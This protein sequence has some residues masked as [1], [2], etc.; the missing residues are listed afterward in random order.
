MAKRPN[1][2]SVEANLRMNPGGQGLPPM[3]FGD[4]DFLEQ[5]LMQ[6]LEA[7]NLQREDDEDEEQTF[8]PEEPGYFQQNIRPNMMA[9][10]DPAKG[11]GDLQRSANYFGPGGSDAENRILSSLPDSSLLPKPVTDQFREEMGYNDQEKDLL[12][13]GRAQAAMNEAPMNIDAQ[14]RSLV[15]QKQDELRMNQFDALM[16]D[17]NLPGYEVT[18]NI[19]GSYGPG[20]RKV[21]VENTD[22]PDMTIAEF[23]E[24]KKAGSLGKS[25]VRSMTQPTKPEPQQQPKL[26]STHKDNVTKKPKTTPTPAPADKRGDFAPLEGET[27]ADFQERTSALDPN[28][29]AYLDPEFAKKSQRID[30]AFIRNMEARGYEKGRDYDAL[31][32]DGV[33][34]FSREISEA[35]RYL[36]SQ[37]DY[38]ATIDDLSSKEGQRASRMVM[39]SEK[40]LR[41]AER[42]RKAFGNM[43]PAVRGAMR[44]RDKLLEKS[45]ELGPLE[46][47]D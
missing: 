37:R 17:Y 5:Y 3:S 14:R 2:T 28:A 43:S 27:F 21:Q 46:E 33:E 11:F 7:Q 12:R 45:Y 39:A 32:S 24:R 8:F 34:D 19:A 30:D 47:E 16:E 25:G 1:E 42:K 15:E 6:M 31:P 22:E 38:L 23:M 36:K 44:N 10:S 29:I 40:R 26:Q 13:I 18:G 9:G 4:Q 20:V 41:D 35:K